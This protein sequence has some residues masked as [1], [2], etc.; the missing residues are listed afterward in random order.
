M[1]KPSPPRGLLDKDNPPPSVVPGPPAPSTADHKDDTNTPGKRS[2]SPSKTDTNTPGKK[3]AYMW[4]PID[5][6]L[7]Q[8]R[9]LI[10]DSTK[11]DTQQSAT[12]SVATTTTTSSQTD[13]TVDVQ[14]D[15][16]LLSELRKELLGVKGVLAGERERFSQEEAVRAKELERL[17]TR[18]AEK[19]AEIQEWIQR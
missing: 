2:A 12:G 6:M 3:S 11:N 15:L 16:G 7:H 4:S 18:L 19:E 13:N 9:R 14:T 17:K 10:P 1:R 8:K 5:R